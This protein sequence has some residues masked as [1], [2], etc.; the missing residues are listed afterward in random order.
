MADK[1]DFLSSIAQEVEDTRKGRTPSKKVMS[2]EDYDKQT[3]I[4]HDDEAILEDLP[5]A[6][7]KVEESPKIK[8]EIPKKPVVEEIEFD[9]EDEEENYISEDEGYNVGNRPRSFEEEK[10]E[11]VEKK[12]IKIDRKT[13]IIMIVIAALAI[14]GIYFVFFAPKITLPDFTGKSRSELTTWLSQNGIQSSVVALSEEYSM[15]YDEDVVISQQ[16]APGKKIHDDTPLNFTISLGPDPDELIAFPD[17]M[18][19]DYDS[20]RA[21]IDENKLLN[22]KIN[23]VYNDSVPENAVIDYNLRNITENNFT[24]GTNLTI[25]I[26]RGKAPA[27][28]VSIEDLSGKTYEE[29]KTWAKNKKIIL[30]RQEA[31][32]DTVEIGKVISQSVESGSTINEG[33]EL[34]VIVS[35]GQAVTIPNL[36]GYDA[37]MLEAWTSDANNKVAVVKRETYSDQ[38]AGTVISQSIEA[39]SQVDQGTVLE[40]GISLYMPQLQTNSQEWYGKDYLSLI[41]VVDGWNAK[42]ANIAVGAWDGEVCDDTYSTPGQIIEYRCL[43]ANGNQL[44]YEANGCARPLPLNA[45]ISM[46][47][48]TGACQVA[49]PAAKDVTVPDTLRSSSDFVLW[50][51]QNGITITETTAEHTSPGCELLNED[52]SATGKN[53]GSYCAFNGQTLTTGKTYILR[54]FVEPAPE[55]TTQTPEPTE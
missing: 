25:N 51:S 36:V 54:K 52:W 17:L 32:S 42:G 34:I 1:K 39:G 37:T 38:P 29:V 20:V 43:D 33:E 5:K 26:S 3:K 44:P 23:T 15:E 18:N 21:W 35:K 7:K 40:L 47:V 27:G 4:N 10:L 13:M 28:K 14:V 45:K 8:R 2:F 19:M 9:E 49:P 30:T 55:P 24:R 31:Y 41:A 46:K 48:S 12:P 6:S 22:T 50:A 53:P 11:K 16:Q